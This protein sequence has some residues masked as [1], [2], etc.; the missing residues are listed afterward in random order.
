MACMYGTRNEA[1]KC[2][3]PS[4]LCILSLFCIWTFIAFQKRLK[5]WK[6]STANDDIGIQKDVWLRGVRTLL[7]TRVAKG[8]GQWLAISLKNHP[9]VTGDSATVPLALYAYTPCIY[10]Y[11]YIQY[12]TYIQ[13]MYVSFGFHWYSDSSATHLFSGSESEYPV[14]V[15][16][17]GSPIASP[18]A[19]RV[20]SNWSRALLRQQRDAWGGR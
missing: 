10:T 11:I 20:A 9:N 4:M 15:W 16:N 19:C 6:Y 13:Y 3:N 17:Y 1:S 8:V 14:S 5:Y 12:T 18:W 7:A 2:P